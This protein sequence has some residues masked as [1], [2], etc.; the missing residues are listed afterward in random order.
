M[1]YEQG[2]ISRACFHNTT[3]DSVYVGMSLTARR[4]SIVAQND[5]MEPH[6]KGEILLVL[7]RLVCLHHYQLVVA[8]MSMY[9]PGGP[10]IIPKEPTISSRPFQSFVVGWRSKDS[11]G[12]RSKD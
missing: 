2:A 1:L 8:A 12:L 11:C 4:C 6:S 3:V 9:G 10:A 5:A 7:L